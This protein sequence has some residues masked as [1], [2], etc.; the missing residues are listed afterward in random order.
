LSP[1]G[2]KLAFKYDGGPSSDKI[3]VV[4]MVNHKGYTIE[5]L[6]W[7]DDFWWVDDNRIAIQVDDDIQL[8]KLT[9]G[10]P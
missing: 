4:D 9:G 3:I 1:S 8:T 10:R 5:S 2:T 7:P 6:N